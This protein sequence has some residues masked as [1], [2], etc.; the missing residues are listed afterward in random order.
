VDIGTIAFV[1]F[2]IIGLA[3]NRWISLAKEA[4][5]ETKRAGIGLLMRWLKK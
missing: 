3:V 5:P 1:A 2:L 4:S